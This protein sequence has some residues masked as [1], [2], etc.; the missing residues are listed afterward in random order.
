MLCIFDFCC[1]RGVFI[2]FSIRLIVCPISSDGCCYYVGVY[3]YVSCVW[4]DVVV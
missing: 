2:T 3:L 1:F 4:G